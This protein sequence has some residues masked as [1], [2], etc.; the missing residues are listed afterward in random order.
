MLRIFCKFQFDLA[1][2]FPVSA[3]DCA[4][5]LRKVHTCSALSGSS[6]LNVAF[7]TAPMVVGL[8]TDYS[9][10]GVWNISGFL[11]P[12]FFPSSNHC[13]RCFG[14]SVLRSSSSLCSA[15]DTCVKEKTKKET[16]N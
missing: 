6:S 14:I 12:L 9:Q 2:Q 16:H 5:V 8:N 1:F 13:C 15:Q 11:S 4:I 7:D 10:S 3:K